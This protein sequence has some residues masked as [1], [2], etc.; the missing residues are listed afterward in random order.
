MR[1]K[2][3]FQ[4]KKLIAFNLPVGYTR[5][6]LVSEHDSC[7]SLKINLGWNPL[8][9]ASNATSTT[10]AFQCRRYECGT[11]SAAGAPWERATPELT[12][13][14]I[15][16]EKG[17]G[18]RVTKFLFQAAQKTRCEQT[19]PGRRDLQSAAAERGQ[20]GSSNPQK[21]SLGTSG[22]RRGACH[23]V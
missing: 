21:V 15:L 23:A 12:L 5:G 7:A 1:L 10:S 14:G 16:G 6:I 2:K 4:L 17:K 9:P 8:A 11:A 20:G 22:E 18:W 13:T 3:F 19:A